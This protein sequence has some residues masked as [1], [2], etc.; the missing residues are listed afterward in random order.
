MSRTSFACPGNGSEV[1]GSV[2]FMMLLPSFVRLSINAECVP[3]REARG[4]L[5]LF[6]VTWPC[7]PILQGR[8]AGCAPPRRTL[9]GQI[10]SRSDNLRATFSRLFRVRGLQAPDFRRG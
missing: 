6:L 4:P 1:A 9:C 7:S 3:N 2:V 10:S 5:Q 8:D